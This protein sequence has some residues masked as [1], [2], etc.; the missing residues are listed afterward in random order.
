MIENFPLAENSDDEVEY[1]NPA[2]QYQ[3]S[4]N[5][6]K[7]Q[8]GLSKMKSV[9]QNKSITGDKETSKDLDVQR[10]Y[11]SESQH[12]LALKWYDQVAYVVMS[13]V[14]LFISIIPSYQKYQTQRIFVLNF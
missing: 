1:K 11:P 4:V 14:H 12:F 9:F 8:Q 10:E 13:P 7:N 6:L 3:G 2:Q 5:L